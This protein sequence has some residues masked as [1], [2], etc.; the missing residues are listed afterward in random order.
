[1]ANKKRPRFA[2]FLATV[3]ARKCQ[4]SKSLP[5]GFLLL[6]VDVGRVSDI[7]RD[8]HAGIGLRQRHHLSL[9]KIR[10][11]DG[12]L[13]V[14]ERRN[15][16]EVER[17][18]TRRPTRS[19][20]ANHRWEQSSVL[21][22]VL[23]VRLALIPDN[24]AKREWNQRT[25]HAVEQ[26]AR[27]PLIHSFGCLFTLPKRHTNFLRHLG[28]GGKL[29]VKL[30]EILSKDFRA[31]PSLCGRA[32]PVSRDQPDGYIQFFME[33]RAKKVAHCAEAKHRLRAAC[34]PL[35]IHF[36]FSLQSHDLGDSA[37][38]NLGVLCFDNIFFEMIQ[39][40]ATHLPLHV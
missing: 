1:M 14:S 37:K 10:G 39:T 16:H 3:V 6:R 9:A 31:D 20:I 19:P 21:L 35:C 5:D 13:L 25:N 2:Y 23:D 15:L 24:A 26:N 34:R 11:A 4:T 30:R 27:V 18:V 33:S 36:V 32:S 12:F 40:E 22:R 38:S 7:H 8:D 28:V 29:L 17:K